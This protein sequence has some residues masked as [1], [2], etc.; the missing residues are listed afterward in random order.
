ME[1]DLDQPQVEKLD[2]GQIHPDI[3]EHI[4]QIGS[5]LTPVIKEGL[6]EFLRQH[7]YCFA[8]S[9]MDMVG[10][11]LDVMVHQLQVDPDQRLVKQKRRKFAPKR[12][13]II[14]DKVQKL[15]DIGSVREVTILI[16]YQT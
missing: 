6:I 16:G 9:H 2:E 12:N 7:H 11:N 1:L 5:R 8:W 13:R 10:I 15:I 3:S 4:V 14:N